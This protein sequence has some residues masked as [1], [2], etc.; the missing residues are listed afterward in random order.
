M[1]FHEP[2]R[3]EIECNGAKLCCA[4]RFQRVRRGWLRLVLR[5]KVVCFL[6]GIYLHVKNMLKTLFTSTPKDSM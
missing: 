6:H 2:L 4:Q 1:S 3:T 5:V